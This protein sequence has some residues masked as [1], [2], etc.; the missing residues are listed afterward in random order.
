MSTTD[1]KGILP[2]SLFLVLN[3]IRFKN[4]TNMSNWDSPILIK[5]YIVNYSNDYF[6]DSKVT[7]G[8]IVPNS[9]I[10]STLLSKLKSQ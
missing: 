6:I 2:N 10:S 8:G 3:A 9:D 7:P 1:Y 4:T 5:D